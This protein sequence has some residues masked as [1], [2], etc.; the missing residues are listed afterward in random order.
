[1]KIAVISTTIFPVPPVGYSGLE[2][3][4]WQQAEGLAKKGHKVLLVA[5]VGSQVPTGGELHGTTIG[6]SEM[7]AYGGYWEKLLGFD[8]VIDS[9]WQKWSYILKAEGKL[10]A[11]VLGVMHTTAE[12]MYGKAPPVDKPCL[13]AISQ[14]Q[15]GA[16]MGQLGVK[17]RVAYN[18]ADPEFYK[19]TVEKRTERYLFLGRMSKLKGPHIAALAAKEC[20]VSLDL[21]GDDKLVE[22]PNYVRAVKSL[23]HGNQ[24]VYHGEKP[25]AECPTYFTSAKALL[26]CNAV[27]REPFGLA[28]VEAMMCGAPVIAW[29]HGA[30]RETV[31]NGETG[32]LVST[33]EELVKLIDSN[34]VKDIDSAACRKW[35]MR[36]S[37]ENMVNRYEELC[38]EAIEKGW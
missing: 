31:K 30:M 10:K 1:M 35:A 25:R 11:P 37:V 13:V 15:A 19:P 26:H 12:T 38:K 4:A 18:G 23:A 33:Y 36:F 34:A 21:V 9:S 7:A 17:S 6:E 22:D 27:F 8:A 14:D 29:N 20:N 2:M 3:I 5:P 28:P 16:I 24:I 32:F